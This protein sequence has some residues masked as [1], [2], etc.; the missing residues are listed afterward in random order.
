MKKLII[1]V[2]PSRSG[3]T[4]NGNI[5]LSE[6]GNRRMYDYTPSEAKS[7][8]SSLEQGFDVWVNV[9]TAPAIPHALRLVSLPEGTKI[10]VRRFRGRH[11]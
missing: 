10:D 4:Y 8:Q 11:T 2:G 1:A 9:N 7:I 5:W 3:K 6:G